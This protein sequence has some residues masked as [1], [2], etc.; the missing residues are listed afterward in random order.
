MPVAINTSDANEQHYEVRAQQGL[1]V[2]FMA[3]GE[4]CWLTCSV[5]R[6][7]DAGNSSY[8][9]LCSPH[10][11][12]CEL[13]TDAAGWMG[14]DAA[15]GNKEAGWC[16]PAHSQCSTPRILPCILYTFCAQ[17]PTPYFLLVLGKHLKYSSCL[18]RNER[19][20]LDQAEENM[21]CEQ[22]VRFCKRGSS[23]KKGGGGSGFTCT[24]MPGGK[25]GLAP[26]P[27]PPSWP[28]PYSCPPCPTVALRL[29]QLYSA[30]APVPCQ[31]L[32]SQH[33]NLLLHT[34]CV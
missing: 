32:P 6:A 5:Q 23:P 1:A 31:H 17:L 24:N 13:L 33:T 25:R 14:K 12:V 34:Q 26:L 3:A 28:D 10:M 8:G 2:G 19:D 30:S 11:H 27:A 4:E 9:G 18:Y 20:T 22:G 15:L 16:L 7:E 29:P 21:L